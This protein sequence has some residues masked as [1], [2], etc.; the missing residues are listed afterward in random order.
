MYKQERERERERFR[1]I[2]RGPSPS[3]GGCGGN[4]W[5]LSFG[6]LKVKIR[7]EKIM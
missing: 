6:L 3:E 5:D 2:F 4:Y 1:E 7:K